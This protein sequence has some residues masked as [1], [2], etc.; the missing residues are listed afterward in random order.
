MMRISIKNPK[1][2]DESI[3]FYEEISP[4]LMKKYK[5]IVIQ[6]KIAHLKAKKP[7]WIHQ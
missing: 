6:S 3:V 1:I 2:E 7:K 4:F 5:E